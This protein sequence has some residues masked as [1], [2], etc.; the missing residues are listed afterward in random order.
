ME[1]SCAHRTSRT[2][3]SQRPNMV[4]KE[5]RDNEPQSKLGWQPCSRGRGSKEEEGTEAGVLCHMR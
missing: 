3:S 1:S 4:R 2:L 5:G